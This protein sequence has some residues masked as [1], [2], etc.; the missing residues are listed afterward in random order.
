[1]SQN[2]APDSRTPQIGRRLEPVAAEMFS[3]ANRQGFSV[4]KPLW[5]V[6]PKDWPGQRPFG[7]IPRCPNRNHR[8]SRHKCEIVWLEVHLRIPSSTLVR[9]YLGG[10]ARYAHA[11]F[12]SP[13]TEQPEP[14]PAL[15][16]R[17]VAENRRARDNAARPNHFARRA[18]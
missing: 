14:I 7:S 3:A 4:P 10:G 5:R 17:L 16:R 6:R 18:D 9:H 2:P 13:R 1:M 12:Q 8:W 11:E 15:T